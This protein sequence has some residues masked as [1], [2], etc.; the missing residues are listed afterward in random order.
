LSFNVSITTGKLKPQREHW[1]TKRSFFFFHSFWDLTTAE[2]NREVSS[3]TCS[4]RWFIMAESTVYW[5]V[6]R[7]KYY[8]MAA[9]SADPAKRTG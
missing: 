2:Q 5:F 3:V 4:F 6:V 9:D 7:E 8:W 1:K